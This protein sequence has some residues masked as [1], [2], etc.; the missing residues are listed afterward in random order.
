[1]TA[2]QLF[3]GVLVVLGVGLAYMMRDWPGARP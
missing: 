3:L 1:M 2:W